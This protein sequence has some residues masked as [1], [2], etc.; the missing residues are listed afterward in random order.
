MDE[1]PAAIMATT[2]KVT[3]MADNTLRL[4]VEIPPKYAKIAFSL[5]GSQGTPV[6]LALITPEASIADMHKEM[7]ASAPAAGEGPHGDAYT[8]L[9]KTGFWFAPPLHEA[10][11]IAGEVE[12]LR[13]CNADPKEII[14]LVKGVIYLTLGTASL[15]HVEPATFRAL[16][17][18]Y[19]VENLLP[20]GFA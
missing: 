14:D 5:F 3:T 10:L 18:E 20:G 2:G 4:I 7:T 15:S 6:A 12:T 9:Y 11:G 8:L 16:M 17:S 1:A 19:G 13:R